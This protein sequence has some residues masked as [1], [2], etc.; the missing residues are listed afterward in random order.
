MAEIVT[1]LALSPTMEEGRL[2]AW[3]KEVGD[4]VEEGEIIAEIET[5][6]ANMDMESFF[7]GT[8]LKLL[9]EPGTDVKVGEP[10]AIIG[11]EGED[12]SGVLDGGGA[13]P[14]APE[15]AAATP[16]AEP[17]Q[18]VAADDAPA[19]APDRDGERVF[20]SPVARKMAITHG[21][22][23]AEIDGSGPRGRVVKRDVEAAIEAASQKPAP[24]PARAAAPALQPTSSP[25][26]E[27]GEQVSLSPMPR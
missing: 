7:E 17:T 24:A 9:I 25:P 5:D 19:E 2:V 6:K 10:I 16:A 15:P 8:L 22:D 13:A 14:E 26:A 3:N 27:G 23:I 18:E 11:E 1:M 20:S 12:I 21:L 4:A